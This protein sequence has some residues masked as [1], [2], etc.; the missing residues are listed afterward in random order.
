VTAQGAGPTSPELRLA[1]FEGPLALLLALVEQ[2]RLAITEI[3]LAEVA[4]QYLEAVRR[5][6]D[7]APELLLEFLVIASR[8][9]LI[10]SRL[11]LPMFAAAETADD[12]S[13]DL[14]ERLRAYRAIR[15]AAGLFQ[16]LEA[17]GDAAYPGGARAITPGAPPIELPQVGQLLRLAQGALGRAS[18]N[19]GTVAAMG[20]DR[21]TV[22]ARIDLLL[23]RLKQSSRLTLDDVA[24][25]TIDEVV[26]TFLAILELY[27]RGHLG[28][29]QSTSFGPLLLLR[30]EEGNASS[31]GSG[32][33]HDGAQAG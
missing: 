33:R 32:G 4:S 31:G 8:L 27:K 14:E 6:R 24:G 23:V 25:D 10:K 7:P 20:I 15:S 22:A 11:L 28:F 17:T 3:S 29:E 12:P 9:L 21:V 19:P 16:A 18:R 1:G 26:A 30:R 13:L 5:L 2:R